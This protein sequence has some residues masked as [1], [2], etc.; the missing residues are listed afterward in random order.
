MCLNCFVF[1]VRYSGAGKATRSYVTLYIIRCQLS[2]RRWSKGRQFRLF[3]IAETLV[4]Y[5]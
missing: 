4:V 1:R 3:N 2:M 5:L